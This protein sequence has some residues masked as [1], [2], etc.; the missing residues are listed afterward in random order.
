MIEGIC[1]NRSIQSLEIENEIVDTTFLHLA[2]FFDENNSLT[3]LTLRFYE[4]G[5]VRAHNIAI[6]LARCKFLKHLSF[7]YIQFSDEAFSDI[8]VTALNSLPQIEELVICDQY[9]GGNG[10]AAH[11]NT[12]MGMGKL[13]VLGLLSSDVDDEGLQSL[14]TGM[15]NCRD[16]VELSLPGNQNISVAGL[17]TLTAFFQ[18]ENCRLERLDLGSVNIGNE[19]AITLA[20]GLMDYKSLT[21]LDLSSNNIGDE[22]LQSLVSGLTTAAN[23]SLETL[24]LSGNSRI[25][26]AGIRS[27]STLIQ[28]ERSCLKELDLSR[29]DIGDDEAVVLADA[30]TSNT[31]LVDL[32]LSMRMTNAVQETFS[33][34]LCD[35]SSINN[36]YSSN[37]ILEMIGDIPYDEYEPAPDDVVEKYLMLNR[38]KA[39][40]EP[41]DRDLIPM[42]KILINHPDLAEMEPF[43]HWK[44]KFLPMIVDWFKKATPCRSHFEESYEAFQRRELSAVYKFIRGVPLLVVDGYWSQQLKQVRV[45]KRRIEEEAKQILAKKR[46]VE[47]EERQ[48]LERLE[49]GNRVW[50]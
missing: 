21:Y 42:C 26:I 6:A 15:R 17:R 33:R 39:Y 25:S 10:F 27:L 41:S 7:E 24:N 43:F 47:E 22:G 14:V 2:P 45:M 9:I 44:L 38:L 20:S 18:S 46:K 49:G 23:A 35:I 40:L 50:V 19:G 12:L 34:L 32:R 16:L 30:L 48:V 37:H 8:I 29:T 31:S 13:K 36:I 11:S 28:S 1:R 4:A 5:D 3:R